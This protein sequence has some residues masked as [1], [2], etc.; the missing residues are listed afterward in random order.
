MSSII[1]SRTY[2]ILSLRG[3]AEILA[4]DGKAAMAGAYS[5]AGEINSASR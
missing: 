5:Y 1:D 3:F 2:P 4:V